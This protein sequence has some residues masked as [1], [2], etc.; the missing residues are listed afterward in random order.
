MKKRVG[1][2]VTGFAIFFISLIFNVP[3]QTDIAQE[4]IEG[5]SKSSICDEGCIKQVVFAK[6]FFGVVGI[7]VM[8]LT[9]M[10][11]SESFVHWFQR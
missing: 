8:V 6:I 1:S 10:S 2:F 3:S 5:I 4:A 7:A 11:L 9:V